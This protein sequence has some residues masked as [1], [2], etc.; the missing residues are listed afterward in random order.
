MQS[1]LFDDFDAQSIRMLQEELAAIG[2]SQTAFVLRLPNQDTPDDMHH[3]LSQINVT[4]RLRGED[5]GSGFGIHRGPFHR[6]MSEDERR[7][8][9]RAALDA[10]FNG[11][12]PE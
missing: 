6:A 1:Y 10:I 12:H 4:F 5:G 7:R 11:K 3:H 2:K 8:E 9:I